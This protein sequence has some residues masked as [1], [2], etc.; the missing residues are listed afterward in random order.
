MI[1]L[2]ELAHNRRVA[3]KVPLPELVTQYDHLLR[4]LAVRR[5]RKEKI[6]AKHRR[7]AKELETPARKINSLHIFRNIAAR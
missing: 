4:L 1:K 7:Q 6:T 2:N 3:I 5:I